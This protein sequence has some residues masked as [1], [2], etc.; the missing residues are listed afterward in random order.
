MICLVNSAIFSG[1]GSCLSLIIA[2][3]DT[4][5]A[6]APIILTPN[7]IFAGLLTNLNQLNDFWRYTFAA[8]SFVRYAFRCCVVNQFR[9]E[10]PESFQA[11][12]FKPWN[13]PT[14]QKTYDVYDA[15]PNEYD[16]DIIALFCLGVGIRLLM[17]IICQ[18]R[19]SRLAKG[20]TQ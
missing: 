19:S 12:P 11:D 14:L 13:I 15:N 17:Y 16:N 20:V 5:M 4:A 2:D 1:I 8:L 7:M 10:S 9:F 3:V 6:I 18:R